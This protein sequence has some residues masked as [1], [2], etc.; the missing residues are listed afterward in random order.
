MGGN[1]EL[2]KD[3]KG[4]PQII[5][6]DKGGKKINVGSSLSD[7]NIEKKLGEGHFG[8]VSLVTSKITKK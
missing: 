4:E 1:L 5:F 2:M 7:F 8:S 3:S 6:I